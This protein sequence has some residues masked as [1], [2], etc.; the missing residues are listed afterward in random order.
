MKKEELAKELVQALLLK[1]GGG[2]TVRVSSFICV[3]DSLSAL[4]VEE[5]FGIATENGLKL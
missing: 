1:E 5:L 3:R 4:P 2:T